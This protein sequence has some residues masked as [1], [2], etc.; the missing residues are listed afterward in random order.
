MVL[1]LIT[2][3][4]AAIIGGFVT[5]RVT[6]R[7]IKVQHITGERTKWRD[8]IR[9]IAYHVHAAAM[10]K[11]KRAERLST[12]LLQMKLNLNPEDE[13][14][15]KILDTIKR[16]IAAGDATEQVLKE[17]GYR[18]ALL[19]KHDWERGKI[20]AESFRK[21]AATLATRRSYEDFIDEHPNLP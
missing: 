18:V 10:A 7:N 5:L 16:L 1:W 20:E 12:L 4:A 6:A 8:K 13:M 19:L 9:R 2:T 14:D 21:R 3:S 11:E 15:Q 17:F